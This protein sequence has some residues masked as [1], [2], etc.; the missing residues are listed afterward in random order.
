MLLV[1]RLPK[2]AGGT[3]DHLV[4]LLV[5]RHS[6]FLAALSKLVSEAFPQSRIQ[7]ATS[8]DQ[9]ATLVSN[10]HFDLAFCE[11]RSESDGGLELVHQLR[12]LSPGTRAILLAD[13]EDAPLLVASLSCGAAGFFTKDTSPAEFLEASAPVLAAHYVVWYNPVRSSLY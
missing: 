4:I 5:D 13:P 6:L 10:E 1:A 2:G 3:S 9:A 12:Q 7:T 11:V 8:L